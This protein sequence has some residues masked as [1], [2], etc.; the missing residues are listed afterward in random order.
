MVEK[1]KI[2]QVCLYQGKALNAPTAFKG[3]WSSNNFQK[4]NVLIIK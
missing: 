4:L 3:S 1:R 2:Q